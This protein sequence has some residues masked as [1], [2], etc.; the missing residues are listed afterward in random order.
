MLLNE[1][2][3]LFLRN[4][5]FKHNIRKTKLNQKKSFFDI[6]QKKK[7]NAINIENG[8]SENYQDSL[9]NYIIILNSIY[10]FNKKRFLNFAIIIEIFSIFKQIEIFFSSVKK[11]YST[12]K[13]LLIFDLYLLNYKFSFYNRKFPRSKDYFCYFNSHPSLYKKKYILSGLSILKQY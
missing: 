10:I 8:K 1:S 11:F 6:T 9:L 4:L 7:F 3:T 5:V 12:T 2:Y 13:F